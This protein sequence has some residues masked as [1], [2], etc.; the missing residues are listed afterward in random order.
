MQDSFWFN[1]LS[2]VH[3]SGFTQNKSVIGLS[4]GST[5][6]RGMQSHSC[7]LFIMDYFTE[8]MGVGR[9]QHAFITDHERSEYLGV[10]SPSES[11]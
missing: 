11:S 5:L 1:G 3:Y 6:L 10:L 7:G 8:S 2:N 4:S 9:M